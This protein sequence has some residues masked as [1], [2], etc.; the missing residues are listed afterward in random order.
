MKQILLRL[1]A[2]CMGLLLLASCANVVM[3]EPQVS[4]EKGESQIIEEI[5][6]QLPSVDESEAEQIVG[7]P[8]ILLTS[9]EALFYGDEE[10]A[11]SVQTAL[12]RRNQLLEEA[13]GM[14]LT[15]IPVE[16][17]DIAGS[18]RVSL[19]GDASIGDLLC[20]SAET[21]AMLWQ[22]GFLKDIKSLPYF[23]SEEACY[24]TVAAESLS[25]GNALYAMADPSA[26]CAD[27]T[28]VLFYDRTLV[29]AAGLARPEA[30]VNAGKW[31]YDK[32]LEYTEKV[33]MEV[34]NKESY[35]IA[36]DVFG[37]GSHDNEMLMPYVLWAST[38]NKLFAAG[39]T[40][41]PA[42]AYD[43]DTL[44]EFLTPLQQVYD[45]RSRFPAG[46]EDAYTAFRQGRLGFLVAKLDY[47]KE[48]FAASD[49]PYGIL[50]L[51]KEEGDSRYHCLMDGTGMLLSVPVAN[52][53]DSKSGL[54][55]GAMCAIGGLL[56]REAEKETYLSLYAMDNDHACMLETVLD[57]GIFDF[58]M[59][60]GRCDDSIEQ[61]STKL[62][63]HALVDHSRVSSLLKSYLDDFDEF[64]EEMDDLLNSDGE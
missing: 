30:L 40:G 34:M 17:N 23:D 51:P 2:A 54:S 25:Y 27:D 61:L 1:T 22:N 36:Q 24:D 63:A 26:R 49:R 58:G 13:Y 20:Y 48:L 50:P 4:A 19:Q 11:G 31:T 29:D 42:Y 7:Q 14:E 5:L 8:L 39:E 12:L 53:S 62:V 32:F 60:F 64:V 57:A 55:L 33:A 35:D 41:K 47:L 10:A 59:T 43:G 44:T 52:I 9:D 3:P 18:I 38:G 16:E 45:S 46:G 28:F 56:V 6:E 37:Y 15:V 21:T